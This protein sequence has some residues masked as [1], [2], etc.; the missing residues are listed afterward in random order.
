MGGFYINSV[1][2][3]PSPR[4]ALLHYSYPSLHA[5]HKTILESRALRRR[6]IWKRIGEKQNRGALA[7]RED[8]WVSRLHLCFSFI[9][10]G[11]ASSLSIHKHRNDSWQILGKED[12]F[13]YESALLIVLLIF[14]LYYWSLVW[15][16]FDSPRGILLVP[17]LCYGVSN[18]ISKDFKKERIGEG[19]SHQPCWFPGPVNFSFETAI[20]FCII[21]GV[22]AMVE[23]SSSSYTW[24]I[25]RVVTIFGTHC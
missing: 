7:S 20:A 8:F 5:L 25:F 11:L 10:L 3:I 6:N 4:I 17:S 14:S 1:R 23:I 12:F 21:D 13:V 19:M 18:D 16:Y 15:V 24:C 9:K 22:P 2:L